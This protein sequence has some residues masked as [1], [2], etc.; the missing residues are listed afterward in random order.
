[1]QFETFPGIDAVAI[2]EMNCE[3]I[4]GWKE[5]PETMPVVSTAEYT[6]GTPLNLA[7]FFF[8]VNPA[9]LI[10][11]MTLGNSSAKFIKKYEISLS[12]SREEFSSFDGVFG[13]IV[14]MALCGKFHLACK[15]PEKNIN[16]TQMKLAQMGF[17]VAASQNGFLDVWW[18]SPVCYPISSPHRKMYFL[19]F[20][21]HE[22]G[23][24]YPMQATFSVKFKK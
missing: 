14:K 19:Y 12:E 7:E 9:T 5:N 15:M 16:S 2:H 8:I 13:A 3:T 20:I 10:Q 21:D 1:M 24:P 23:N 4:N 17:A 22:D 18:S 6:F 11:R